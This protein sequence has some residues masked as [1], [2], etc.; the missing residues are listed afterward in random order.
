MLKS[1]ALTSPD[2]FALNPPP[3]EYEY[4][5]MPIDIV[6][7]DSSLSKFLL[8]NAAGVEELEKLF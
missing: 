2:N 5:K 4:E 7:G 8:D 1:I 6:W 3:Y